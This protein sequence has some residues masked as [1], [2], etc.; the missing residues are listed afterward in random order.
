MVQAFPFSKPFRK[1]V[2]IRK[3]HALSL[4]TVAHRTLPLGNLV[5]ITGVTLRGQGA[6]VP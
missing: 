6:L 4:S 3:E 5:S 2:H 1:R